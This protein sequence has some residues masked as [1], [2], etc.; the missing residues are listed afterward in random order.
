MGSI[1]PSCFPFGKA[2][3]HQILR[4]QAIAVGDYS[5]TLDALTLK[6]SDFCNVGVYELGRCWK[7]LREADFET[8]LDIGPRRNRNFPAM[9]LDDG[10]GDVKPEAG[11]LVFFG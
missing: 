5:C 2:G 10:F 8:G 1:L 6:P 11:S 3:G 7:L 9:L 4:C